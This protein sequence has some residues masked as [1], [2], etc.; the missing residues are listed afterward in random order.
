MMWRAPS[1]SWFDGT[2]AS[3]QNDQRGSEKRR[4]APAQ[5]RSA[6]SSTTSPKSRTRFW[7]VSSCL[8]HLLSGCAGQLVQRQALSSQEPETDNGYGEKLTDVIEQGKGE[9]LASINT[10]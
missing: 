8:F 6:L 9:R 2:A 3:E 5:R 7:F 1:S 4:M 10:E